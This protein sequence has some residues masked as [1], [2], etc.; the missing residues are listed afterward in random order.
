MF[1]GKK[2]KVEL[3]DGDNTDSYDVVIR[4][5]KRNKPANKIFKAKATV[6]GFLDRI[7]PQFNRFSMIVIVALFSVGV[8]CNTISEDLI[9]FGTVFSLTYGILTANYF[10]KHDGEFY[11]WTGI[12]LE[13]RQSVSSICLGIGLI[14]FIIECAFHPLTKI[15]CLTVAKLMNILLG[16]SLYLIIYD[17]K[18]NK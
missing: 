15:P 12:H 5:K 4:I 1:F 10:K 17:S 6:N 11:E 13:D 3:Q 2:F 7:V 16:V 14:V 9:L 18:Q 8:I